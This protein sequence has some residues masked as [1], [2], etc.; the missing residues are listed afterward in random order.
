MLCI[1]TTWQSS[2]L[3]VKATK[4]V[5]AKLFDSRPGT[6]GNRFCFEDLETLFIGRKVRYLCAPSKPEVLIFLERAEHE[7]KTLNGTS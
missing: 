6:W 5:Q 4:A 1:D 7:T 3:F 2:S